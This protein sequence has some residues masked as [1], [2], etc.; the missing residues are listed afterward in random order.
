MTTNLKRLC[1]EAE[2][3]NHD[4]RERGEEDTEEERKEEKELGGRQEHAH[5]GSK[6]GEIETLNYTLFHELGSERSE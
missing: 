5:Y 1:F 2:G 3:E 6:Q 4:A